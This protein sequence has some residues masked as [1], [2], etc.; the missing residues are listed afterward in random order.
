MIISIMK[1]GEDE[2]GGRVVRSSLLSPSTLLV[3]GEPFQALCDVF[4]QLCDPSAYQPIAIFLTLNLV[5]LLLLSSTGPHRHSLKR[6]KRKGGATYLVRNS[7]G[8]RKV[9]QNEVLANPG[10]VE[11]T[12]DRTL[13]VVSSDERISYH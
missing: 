6:G 4:L 9:S 7:S 5:Q 12:E 3:A 11:F 13:S 10:V 2:D 1:R 8:I